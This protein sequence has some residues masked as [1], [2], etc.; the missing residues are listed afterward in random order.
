VSTV[1]APRC[2]RVNLTS[3]RSSR[4]PARPWTTTGEVRLSTAEIRIWIRYAR[5]A[6]TAID[7]EG[8]TARRRRRIRK[9]TLVDDDGWADRP[10]SGG[11]RDRK[12]KVLLRARPPRRGN[13]RHDPDV[14]WR[15]ARSRG[16]HVVFPQDGGK[17]PSIGIII[18]I[19]HNT[20]LYNTTKI[21]CTQSYQLYCRPTRTT[22]A[23]ATA[24]AAALWRA[25]PSSSRLATVRRP[26][27]RRNYCHP[28][29]TL[30]SLPVVLRWI[31]RRR[32]YRC[33][34]CCCHRRSRRQPSGSTSRTPT[35]APSC[36]YRCISD[37]RPARRQCRSVGHRR[38]SLALVF[39]VVWHRYM[40]NNIGIVMNTGA[41]AHETG[42]QPSGTT[43]A[44]EKISNTTNTY[45]LRTR[46]RPMT[47]SS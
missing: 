31:R 14:R 19:I 13:T 33:C 20:T 12:E 5:R 35:V 30:S 1:K 41:T 11:K 22:V 7:T 4:P 26:F 9:R 28:F 34:C 8:C 27:R 29:W 39:H 23:A 10:D 36:S 42:R 44:A 17:P 25:V 21:L 18:V 24:A 6:Q 40:Y 32:R 37:G 45:Y 3:K 38:R 2:T 43:A 15:R 47:I 46:R 16:V